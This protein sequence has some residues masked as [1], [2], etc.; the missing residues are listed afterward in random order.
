MG[1]ILSPGGTSSQ[2]RPPFDKYGDYTK[3]FQPTLSNGGRTL[4]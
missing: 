3:H 1:E 2:A 4:R